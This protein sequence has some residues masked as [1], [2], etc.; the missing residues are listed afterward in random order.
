MNVFVK[1]C[2]IDGQPALVRD[3]SNGKPLAANGEWKSKTQF[4]IRRIMQGDV[5]D[6]TKEQTAAQAKEAAAP[7]A[8]P[9][10]APASLPAPAADKSK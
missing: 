1:P 8:A 7:S 5:V 3:P 10:P 2:L 6:L 9:A 4:W